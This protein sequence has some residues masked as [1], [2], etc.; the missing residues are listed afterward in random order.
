MLERCGIA[1]VLFIASRYIIH[2]IPS[3]LIIYGIPIIISIY[4]IIY[5]ITPVLKYKAL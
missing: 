2:T 5:L 1:V 3:M 4:T